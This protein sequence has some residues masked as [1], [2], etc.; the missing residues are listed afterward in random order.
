MTGVVIL[1]FGADFLQAFAEF[2]AGGVNAR[3]SENWPALYSA[4]FRFL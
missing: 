2:V 4:E 1:I 3:H